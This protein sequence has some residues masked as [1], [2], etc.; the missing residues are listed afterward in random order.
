MTDPLLDRL[1]DAASEAERDRILIAHSLRHLDA[2]A[3]N[4]LRVGAIPHE[5][6]ANFLA[7]LA[8]VTRDT[9]Q[10]ACAALATTSHVR[11]RKGR[12]QVVA[13]TRS[14]LLDERWDADRSGF[15]TLSRRA[16]EY[17]LRQDRTDPY[18]FGEYIY[19]ASLAE[20][21]NAVGLARRSLR[22]WNRDPAFI[23]QCVKR[24]PKMVGEHVAAGRLPGPTPTETEVWSDM[25][26]MGKDGLRVALAFEGGGAL[27]AYQAGVY[28]A[29]AEQ[30]ILPEWVAGESMGAVNAALIAG[31]PPGRRVEALRR[32]WTDVSRE[33]WPGMG[34]LGLWGR[35]KSSTMGVPGLFV[36]RPAALFAGGT[37]FYDT[38]PL[39]QTLERLV[40]FDLLNNGPVRFSVGATEATTGNFA[41]FDTAN[42]RV[43]PDHIRASGAM[44]PAF[45]A[46]T[47][48]GKPYW[49][50]GLVSTTALQHILMGW[51]EGDLDLVVFQ[52]HL[53]STSAHVPETI[54]ETQIQAQNIRYAS[55]S[56]LVTDFY[57]G[58]MSVR[59]ALRSAL[60]RI[61]EA[62]R[63]SRDR[64]LLAQLATLPRASIV[65]L[66]Y[67]RQMETSR[68]T[69]DDFSRAAIEA[70]WQEGLEDGQRVLA[71]GRW[72]A[73]PAE[74]GITIVDISET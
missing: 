11:R 3:L 59:Q 36:P 72:A 31:N 4:L 21:G 60:E 64:A 49:D 8:G 13:A 45:P 71:T 18:W 30:G 9:A 1:N 65:N 55:R 37:S 57:A 7:D 2:E 73:P 56:R 28:E 39:T 62:E 70:H 33:I 68:L 74:A 17:C 67:R 26:R 32:F 16:A 47:I 35:T 14:A 53:F 43:G 27:C 51:Q 5:F 12:Y 15:L 24:L 48:D 66:V 6:D 46:V 52:V 41:I 61:P 38:T 23:E 69:S 22:D 25:T 10:A 34:A 20:P 54:E 63:S 50:G 40:D 29:L 19:H 58:Q 44:P 42:M